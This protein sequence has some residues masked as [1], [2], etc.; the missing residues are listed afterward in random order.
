MASDL[1]EGL[2]ALLGDGIMIYN[3]NDIVTG[4]GGEFPIADYPWRF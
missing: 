3:D 4:S 1:G 2:W